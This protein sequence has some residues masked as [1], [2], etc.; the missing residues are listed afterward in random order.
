VKLT[1]IF[2]PVLLLA[3]AA[4]S[5]DKTLPAAQPAAAY[6]AHEYHSHE[7]VTVGIDPYDT[8]TKASVFKV[9]YKNYSLLP[10]RLIIS[11][12]GET[13]LMLDSMKIELITANKDKLQPAVIDD[14]LRKL[15]RPE[16]AASR[17]PLPIPLPRD[18]SPV[19]RDARQE[20]ETLMF[21]NVPVTPHSTNS[22]FLFF[23]VAG[24][25]NPESQAHLFI[26]GIRAGDQELFYFDIPMEAYLSQPPQK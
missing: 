18:R 14:I 8:E 4:L 25:E 1:H 12:D 22:G 19:N 10:V 11:N 26:S 3:C 24:I 13:P 9:K 20:I 16:K 21:V 6:P 15:V 23:D 17:S 7:K 5:S 2:A